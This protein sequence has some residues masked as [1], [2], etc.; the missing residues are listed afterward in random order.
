MSETDLVVMLSE[1]INRAWILQTWYVS[2][3]MAVFTFS[4]F[5]GNKLSAAQVLFALS[6]Y[7]LYCIMIFR[8]LMR[9]YPNIY[10]ARA[11][12][13]SLV[14]DGSAQTQLSQQL[15]VS[16]PDVEAFSFTSVLELSS[17]VLFFLGAV[18]YLFSQYKKGKK[19]RLAEAENPS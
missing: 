3:T 13:E 1:Y 18:G 9:V 2:V 17:L 12:L 6:T 19:E 8:N 11:D 4:Y 14:Q 15:L 7:T 10:A 16:F 5:A